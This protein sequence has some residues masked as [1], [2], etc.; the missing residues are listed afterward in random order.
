LKWE[1]T[2]DR[3]ISAQIVERI[4]RGILSG[5][6]PLGSN[7]PSVRVLALEAGVNPNTMQKALVEL[8]GLGLLLTQRT[9]GRTVTV[10]ERLIMELRE[11]LAFD[12]INSYFAGMQSLGFERQ[13]AAEMLL[14]KVGEPSVTTIDYPTIPTIGNSPINPNHPGSNGQPTIEE[15]R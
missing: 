5:I 9:S 10:N 4:Q 12:Y 14:T 6:Y 11:Q 15:T 13:Q 8:E 3:S 1:F 7:M 2:N